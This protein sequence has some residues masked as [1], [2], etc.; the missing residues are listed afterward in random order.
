MQALFLVSIIL[1]LAIQR[2]YQVTAVCG[3]FTAVSMLDLDLEC[4]VAR[5]VMVPGSRTQLNVSAMR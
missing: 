1:C 5:Y 4:V 3:T 2:N